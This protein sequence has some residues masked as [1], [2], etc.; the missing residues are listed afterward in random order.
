MR[1]AKVLLV[2][3]GML[4]VTFLSCDKD[5]GGTSSSN[6]TYSVDG[7]WKGSTSQGYTS[8]FT[9]AS[10]ALTGAAILYRVQGQ[11][12]TYD[13]GLLVAYSV[14]KPING[15]SFSVTSSPPPPQVGSYTFAGT[16]TS[17]TTASGTLT[18]ESTTCNGSGSATWTATKQ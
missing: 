2:A 7:S 16:F 17:N 5:E 1:S 18:F 14:P 3:L 15:N 8:A 6:T 4:I 12:C 9:V 13:A 11:N 10:H